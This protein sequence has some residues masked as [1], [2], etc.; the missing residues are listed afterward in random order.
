[1]SSVVNGGPGLVAVGFSGSRL[2]GDVVSDAVVWT[3]VD[4]LTW[5]RVPDAEAVFGEAY[6]SSVTVGGPGLVA[7]GVARADESALGDFGDGAVWTSVDGL[8]WLRAPH[9]DAVLGGAGPQRMDEVIVGGPG[10]VAVGKEGYCFEIPGCQ[11]PPGS[12]NVVWTSVDGITWS[13]VPH[14]DAVFGD[15]Y[16]PS[17]TVGGP[18]LVAVGYGGVIVAEP[19]ATPE[20]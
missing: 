11:S 5:S 17:V 8:T 3:S 13:R 9:D 12:P 6:M 15:V 7:V 16:T 14:D 10:L 2:E 20:D 19:A 1:M 18:G 4:G